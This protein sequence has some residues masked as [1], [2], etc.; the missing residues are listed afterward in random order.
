MS[1]KNKIS[2]HVYDASVM[3]A[4]NA[5]A[6]AFG[7]GLVG[8]AGTVIL[9][10]RATLKVAPKM[11]AHKAELIELKKSAAT[12]VAKEVESEGA[13]PNYSEYRKD[14]Y[15]LWSRFVRECTRAYAV[16]LLLGGVSAGLLTYSH[17]IQSN[18]ITGL[19]MAYEGL[20]VTFDK[21]REAVIE[22]Q[23]LDA[24]TKYIV[25]AH[26]AANEELQA[27]TGDSEVFHVDSRFVFGRDSSSDFNS[28]ASMW[29]VNF[30][31]DVE[32]A[33]NRKLDSQGIV[34]LNEVLVALG[35]DRTPAGQQLGWVKDPDDSNHVG[36]DFGWRKLSDEITMY[37]LK[38]A[39]SSD[40]A[41]EILL[42][43]NYDGVVWDKL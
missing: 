15:V 9:T 13:V 11:E 14:S 24:D 42:D 32:A 18:M 34:F 43:F 16:P 33:M 21:Y 35:M 6:L 27:R 25:E 8:M 28:R 40:S 3:F 20:K 17:N 22:D 26:N 38:N 37:N 7:A 36:I 10:A 39:E 1:F 29:N 31:N 12:N 4:K 30:L 41:P 23:G 19:T 2:R 5:P